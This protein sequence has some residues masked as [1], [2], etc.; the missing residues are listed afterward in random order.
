MFIIKA[1]IL[2]II[3]ST[4]SAIGIV[5]SKKY[6]NR[7]Q[8]LKEI[9]SA[10]NIFETKIKFTYEPIPEIFKEISQNT[11]KSISEVFEAASNKMKEMSAGDAWNEA[12][13]NS[14]I[15]ITKEDKNVLKGLSKLL[16]KTNI[17]G[18][19]SEIELTTK[20]LDKQIETAEKQK[21]K[22]EKLYKTLGMTIGLAIVILLI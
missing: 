15:E 17:E 20:F 19:I 13:D 5:I 8:N 22:N 10:L 14:N 12:I 4:S 7:V 1:I 3:F 18:Q 11:Y 2:T 21:E 16:G 9:K 6:S